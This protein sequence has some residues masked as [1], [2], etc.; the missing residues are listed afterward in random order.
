MP[1]KSTC[2][3]S[4][5][6]QYIIDLLNQV[7]TQFKLCRMLKFEGP[8]RIGHDFKNIIVNTSLS[9]RV[10]RYTRKN[11]EN[12]TQHCYSYKMKV[13]WQDRA[14]KI[15]KR[16]QHTSRINRLVLLVAGDL[17]NLQENKMTLLATA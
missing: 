12:L 10:L 1:K 15:I 5:F 16:L 7:L 13:T 2:S 4:S 11:D 14:K 3:S 8:S 6:I 9:G 17:V